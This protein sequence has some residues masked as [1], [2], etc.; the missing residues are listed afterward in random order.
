MRKRLRW[1]LGVL[2]I[3]GAALWAQ[4]AP[5]AVGLSEVANISNYGGAAFQDE[6]AQVFLNALNA[7]GFIARRIEKPLKAMEETP[8]V[9]ASVGVAVRAVTVRQSKKNVNAQVVL[10]AALGF[11]PQP[12]LV[13][14]AFAEGQGQDGVEG[15]AVAKAL[16]AAAMAAAQKLAQAIQMKGQVLLSP[17]Y[18]FLPILRPSGVDRFYERTVRIS[19]DMTS[20]LPVGAEVVILKG[21]RPIASGQ[22]VEVDYGSSLV[23]LT[24]V[25]P[26]ARIETGDRVQVT[27]LP[28]RPLGLPLPLRHEKEFRR[29]E[30]DFGLALLIAGVAAALIGE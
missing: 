10:E 11:L 14:R 25:E 16:R 18:A 15:E 30:R 19:L 13:I 7:S 27:T 23:A 5:L 4:P 12:R 29:A 22:V 28:Q 8:P 3:G 17:A 6:V 26:D 2:T 20:G 9:A 24:R 1:V 21:D